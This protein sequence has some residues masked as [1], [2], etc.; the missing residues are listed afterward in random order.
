MRQYSLHP[1]GAADYLAATRESIAVRRKHLPLVAFLQPE[2][3]GDDLQ[4][5][6]HFYSYPNGLD[7]RAACRAAA[8]ADPAWRAYVS[9]SRAHVRKQKNAALFEWPSL[10]EASGAPWRSAGEF[11]SRFSSSSSSPPGIYELRTYRISPTASVRALVR[12]FEAGLPAKCAAARRELGGESGGG[13]DLALFGSAQIGALDTVVELWR[14]SSADACL[15]ARVAARRGAPEWS[16]AVQSVAQGVSDFNVQ[17]LNPVCGV[18]P[19][20]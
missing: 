16:R 3:G 12:A 6:T 13:C 11:A 1:S 15:R 20:Q 19:M 5:L 7:E 8:I 18:S 17:L 14:Y 4:Q 10:Y 2:L 9:S